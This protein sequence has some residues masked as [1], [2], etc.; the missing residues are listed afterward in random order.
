ML[1]LALFLAAP[2][3]ALAQSQATT[4]E[5]NGR[6][7]DANGGVLPGV[8]VTATSPQTGYMREVVSNEEGLFS[9]PLLPPG[10]YDVTAELSGFATFRQTVR[11]TVGATVTLNPTLTVAGV[12]EVITV[13]AAT[14]LVETSSSIR[15]NTVDE[16]AI[17]NLPINGRRFQDFLTLTPTAQV[18]TS[19]GQISFAGQ[20]GINSNVSI[21]G[22]DYNQ[23]FFG[24]IRGGE[25]SNNAFTVPQ[26]AIQEFQ[27]VA[28]GYSAEFG[29]STGG[30][31]N[32]IT[33]SGTNSPRGSLFYVNRNKDWAE[34]NAFG[35][36]AAPTQQQWGGSIGGP[37]AQNRLFYFVAGEMQ[38]LK[39]T[40]NVVF[41]LTGITPDADNAEAYNFF[42]GQEEP[43]EATNDAEAILGRVD[44]QMPEG[45]RLAVRYSFSNNKAL[46]SNATGN[47]LSDTTISALSNNGTER[48]R[49]NTVVSEFTSALS[50]NTLLEI[51]GQY[52][53]EERP[54]DANALHAAHHGHRRQRRYG[55]LPR[56]EH[57]AGLARPA[58]CQRHVGQG[59]PLGEVRARI[60]PRGRVAAVWLRSVQHLPGLRD[61][62][63]ML[64]IL[65]V[66]GP[67]ANR[68]DSPRSVVQFRRQIGNLT[69]ALSTDELALFAQDNWRLTPTFTF[70]Y[71]L[72]WEGTF[73]P[74]PEANND[75]ILNQLNGRTFPIGK[76]I[77]PTQIPNQMNQFGPRV[78][79]AWNPGTGDTVVRGYSGIYYA[80]SPM[81]LFSDPMSGF[82]V[83]PGNLTVT[84]P[85]QVP[86][87]NPNDTLYEQ[88]LLIGINLNT[89]PLGSLPQLTPEQLTAI[90]NALGITANPY[91]RRERHGRGHRV[92]ESTRD[93]G[94]RRYR[95][96]VRHEFQPRCG[97]HLRE[98]RPPPAQS[99]SQHRRAGATADRPGAAPHLPGPAAVHAGPGADSRSRV[100]SSEYTAMTLSSRL[101]RNWALLNVNYVLSKSMSDDDNE[102]D[103]GG[104]LYENTF[105][106]GPEWGPARLDRRHQFNGYAVFFLPYDCGPVDRL[107]LPERAA[108]RRGDRP[109]HQQQPRR[110]RSSLQ[111]SR[112][113]RS[114]ATASGTS[115]SRKS[116]SARSGDRDSAGTI[117]CSSRSTSS[118]CST[119]TTSGCRARQSQTTVPALRQTTAASARR[120]IRT[121]CR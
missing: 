59:E 120:R 23:P 115:R 90:A 38:R 83:P 81:L 39:N 32:A 31:V 10:N 106:L 9:L 119:P 16:E 95:A 51:R 52:S 96:G 84:L 1:A 54:R 57:P 108:N 36:T 72:R 91:L 60:Q 86:V 80:R 100:P 107:P 58:G 82:R 33:K 110:L 69:T 118:T 97:R 88:L 15:T 68:F 99:R 67:T 101:R 65:S 62:Q 111:R 66:G 30:I 114:N 17:R 25:R 109:R 46:N 77:D 98:D 29:R 61:F 47:A 4:A 103:S 28:S 73:N 43:F 12:Q 20:R 24:G 21:D 64:E 74:T 117:A 105:D 56:R 63:A 14:P 49:T 40:R 89:T 48:D 42:K 75:A 22:A 3:L 113:R 121:S 2:R 7:T 70:N 11:A 34:R 26:E 35:Q 8:T 102:R 19:R 76:G 92:Q 94:R 18:D 50:S 41:S 71:G 79:F 5:I 78:G 6:L 104:V 45:N 27:V 116:I 37:I 87:T 93:A 53:R 44:Y 112:R 13:E 85:Y 55:Q